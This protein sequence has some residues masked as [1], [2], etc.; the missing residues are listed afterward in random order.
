MDKRRSRRF[1]LNHTV[2]SEVQMK[3]KKNDVEQTAP[4]TDRR[5]RAAAAAADTDADH[6]HHLKRRLKFPLSAIVIQLV[7]VGLLAKFSD[8]PDDGN[9]RL[10]RQ[11]DL[12]KFGE[13]TTTAHSDTQLSQVSSTT[14]SSLGLAV[15]L[16]MV[17]RSPTRLIPETVR[18]DCSAFRGP[19]VE[20][21]VNVFGPP[22]Q[23]SQFF[24]VTGLTLLF[25]VVR[26][27]DMTTFTMCM[28]VLSLCLQWA[29]LTRGFFRQLPI[30]PS[31]DVFV[32]TV[33]FAAAVMISWGVLL[34]RT[35]PTQILV[36]SLLE[37][38]AATA[39]DYFL[40]D[41]LYVND[42]G[43]A[44]IYNMFGTYFGLAVSWMLRTRGED[45]TSCRKPSAAH[46]ENFGY[47]GT[48]ILWAFWPTAMGA[49]FT[50]SIRVRCIL[51]T[52]F[53]LTGS[54]VVGIA[55]VSLLDPRGKFTNAHIQ[56]VILAGAVAMSGAANT[57][58]GLHGAVCVGL[59]AGITSA[60]TWA[61]VQPFLAR[62]FN[63]V[64]TCG[65]HTLHGT[66]AVFGVIVSAVMASLADQVTYG[67]SLYSLFPAMAPP[68]NTTE[69]DVI[70]EVWPDVKPGYGRT[71]GTQAGYQMIAMVTTFAAAIISGLITGF[72]MRQKI[73]DPLVCDEYYND[74]PLFNMSEQDEIESHLRHQSGNGVK[75]PPQLDGTDN[76]GLVLDN[77]VTT[78]I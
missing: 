36:M 64:D 27:H 34:G 59:L 32:I 54:G 65:S 12:D 58:M 21:P 23:D 61:Y 40:L 22:Y 19:N 53:S 9:S 1:D 77:V 28:F 45:I 67:E 66:P 50:G 33:F 78:R 68:S 25:L 11:C 30:K 18:A 70:Q 43:G 37:I 3:V 31:P 42:P 72:I 29:F 41:V 48:T 24:I 15:N 44:L 13:S 35:S 20:E 5:H 51:N 16:T 76:R 62:R 39:N 17:T 6:Q 57:M 52:Y 46:T 55:V 73:F 49:I 60:T 69:L 71:A 2:V 8:Y 14:T 74:A 38:P 10:I 26:N 7:F 4:D 75:S 47:I 63:I 56:N